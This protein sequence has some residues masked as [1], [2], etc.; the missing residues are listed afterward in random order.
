M[1]TRTRAIRADLVWDGDSL[2]PR[3]ALLIDGD[4]VGG[5]VDESQ[6]STDVSV[7]DWGPVAVIP[8]TVN[9]HGHA[10]QSLLKGFADDRV[11]ES[12]RDDVLY[13][14]SERLDA[15]GIYA[16]ALFAFAEA[17]LAGTT[18]TV[19]F[20]YLHDDG[21]DN[22]EMVIE[23][24]HRL[25]IRLVLARAFYDLDAPTSAPRRYRED[26]PAAARRCSCSTTTRLPMP[27][28]STCSSSR[29]CRIC[30]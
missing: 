28:W 24:A 1:D 16:G 10:F 29:H 6:V 7:E 19:D 5:V 4:R 26:A 23:A 18:T 9:A 15:R 30:R 21:N 20:F 25:G 8:G 13:P 22:A 12:W 27:G 2:A 3:R 14:F 11:F 17:L